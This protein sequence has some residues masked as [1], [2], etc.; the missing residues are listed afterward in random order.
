LDRLDL[1]D[2]VICTS[3]SERHF[4]LNI[5]PFVAKLHYTS[6]IYFNWH[7][8]D[9]EIQVRKS[10]VSFEFHYLGKSFGTLHKM[11]SDQ[12]QEGDKGTVPF[13]VFMAAE[14]FPV[15]RWISLS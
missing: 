5:L 4:I 9:R 14:A 1:S 2:S 6:R 11:S 10:P 13:S 15:E 8:L 12:V 3:S 7:F